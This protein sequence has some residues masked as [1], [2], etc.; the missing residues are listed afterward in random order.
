MI[1][2]ILSLLILCALQLGVILYLLIKFHVVSNPF[3]RKVKPRPQNPNSSVQVCQ[4]C[5]AL[6]AIRSR[7]GYWVCNSCKIIKL[8]QI[9]AS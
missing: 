4:F 1:E 9:N 2:M 6:G 8:G 7:D 3:N 5:G